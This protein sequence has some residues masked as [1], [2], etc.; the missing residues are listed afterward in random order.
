MAIN[1]TIFQ[2]YISND[3][4]QFDFNKNQV[5][6][7]M[8]FEFVFQSYLTERFQPI[9]FQNVVANDTTDE[10]LKMMENGIWLGYID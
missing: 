1:L 7:E 5:S 2:F 6:I 9:V 8:T 4:F 3:D 10:F